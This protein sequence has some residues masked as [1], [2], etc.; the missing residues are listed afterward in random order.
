MVPG[1]C[2]K[3][4]KQSGHG[5]WLPLPWDPQSLKSQKMTSWS[6][7][8]SSLTALLCSR[9]KW[10]GASFLCSVPL[11]TLGP[12]A[13]LLGFHK[14]SS[15]SG[16]QRLL[17]FLKCSP[18]GLNRGHVMSAFFSPESKAQSFLLI[19]KKALLQISL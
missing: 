13:P 12:R 10:R 4:S 14:P 5:C 7:S 17:L 2:N 11:L 18:W 9:R 15:A 6:H 8:W 16:P 1:S 3:V 19:T